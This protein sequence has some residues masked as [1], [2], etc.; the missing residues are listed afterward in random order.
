MD[1]VQ[2]LLFPRHRIFK[3]MV[4]YDDVNKTNLTKSVVNLN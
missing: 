4:E 2:R 3:S 1:Y